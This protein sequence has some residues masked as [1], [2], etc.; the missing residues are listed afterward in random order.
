M[1]PFM[2]YTAGCENQFLT[3][4]RKLIQ[5]DQLKPMIKILTLQN[6]MPEFT[7]RHLPEFNNTSE[8]M[9]N[10]GICYSAP[11][12]PPYP[13]R[14]QSVSLITSTQVLLYVPLEQIHHIIKEA[15]RLLKQGGIFIATIH[16]Y[17]QYSIS[18]PHLSKFNFLRYS[19]KIWD[20]YFNN[21]ITYYNRLRAIDYQE[22]IEEYP[23]EIIYWQTEG[24]SMEDIKELENFKIHRDFSRYSKEE[25]SKAELTLVIEK[26][27][28]RE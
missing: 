1:I 8:Y 3:D 7:R 2:F 19:K 6:K 13:L 24:G 15:A 22:I 4:I 9:G 5:S 20:K 17:D 10:I 21:S 27:S 14:D 23:F 12:L 16:L 28:L 18:D 11:C 26:K 25:L